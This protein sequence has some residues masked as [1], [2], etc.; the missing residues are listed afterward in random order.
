MVQRRVH[1]PLHQLSY[2]SLRLQLSAASGATASERKSGKVPVALLA[3]RVSKTNV[4]VADDRL[5]LWLALAESQV[6]QH[7]SIISLHDLEFCPWRVGKPKRISG[8][9]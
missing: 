6:A 9:T 5:C 8:S 1:A 7:G 2:I 3:P 4:R